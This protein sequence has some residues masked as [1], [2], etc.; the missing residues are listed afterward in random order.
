MSNR[1]KIRGPKSRD[2]KYYYRL[3]CGHIRMVDESRGAIIL[4]ETQKFCRQ[5]DDL[6]TVRGRAS[7]YYYDLPPDSA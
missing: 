5:C 1:D 6:K 2:D 4:G 7:S 3:W